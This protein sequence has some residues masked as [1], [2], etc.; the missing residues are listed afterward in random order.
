MIKTKSSSVRGRRSITSPSSVM[1]AASCASSQPLW[2]TY[3]RTPASRNCFLPAESSALNWS[4]TE[5]STR[6][7]RKN[8][9]LP[10]C[11][12]WSCFSFMA[13]NSF[14]WKR[15]LTVIFSTMLYQLYHTLYIFVK[16]KDNEKAR[17]ISTPGIADYHY[18]LKLSDF[19]FFENDDKGVMFGAIGVPPHNIFHAPVLIIVTEVERNAV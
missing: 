2:G 4:K 7:S 9:T 11:A 15:Y 13:I 14:C 16:Q 3:G 18:G 5:F 12:P 6:S 19:V 8:F 10:K 17:S 1:K